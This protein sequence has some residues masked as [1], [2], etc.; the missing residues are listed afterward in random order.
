MVVLSYFNKCRSS[1]WL[2]L[3]QMER[4]VN[5]F[6]AAREEII[7]L[8]RW[9]DSHG[10][11]EKAHPDMKNLVLHLYHVRVDLERLMTMK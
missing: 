6:E 2:K 10:A 8:Q 11:K 3:G 9:V 1:C 5:G 4:Y 7:S